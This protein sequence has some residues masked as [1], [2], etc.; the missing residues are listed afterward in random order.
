M[1]L[2]FDKFDGALTG[3]LS[4]NISASRVVSACPVKTCM[5]VLFFS[6]VDNELFKKLY[7]LLT[8]SGH[9]YA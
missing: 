2:R 5:D 1:P 9:S 7:T 8:T 6:L 4:F 3:T